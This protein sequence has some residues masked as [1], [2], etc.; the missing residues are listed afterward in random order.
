MFSFKCKQSHRLRTC[1]LKNV[2]YLLEDLKQ[3]DHQ[4]IPPKSLRQAIYNTQIVE[5]FQ[6]KQTGS[7]KET[8][9][10]LECITEHLKDFYATKSLHA[11]AELEHI[12]TEGS[13][14]CNLLEF[15]TFNE[16]CRKNAG[17]SMRLMLMKQLMQVCFFCSGKC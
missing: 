4:S 17:Q 14:S 12:C 11:V 2:V 3:I 16:N 13:S 15:R 8:C 1:G 9:R 10:Y 7:I 5:N 6:T